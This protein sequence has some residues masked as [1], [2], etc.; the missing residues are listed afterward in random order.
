MARIIRNV[1]ACSVCEFVWMSTWPTCRITY[2]PVRGG[3]SACVSVFVRESRH[4]A[5]IITA[6]ARVQ[7]CGCVRA[8]ASE[9]IRCALASTSFPLFAIA[10]THSLAL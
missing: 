10:K 3:E 9:S 1:C 2:L 7:M 4:T 8:L 5:E 6:S